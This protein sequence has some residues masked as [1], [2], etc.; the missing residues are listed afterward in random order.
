MK[1]VFRVDASIEMGIG[2]VM[3]CLTL[4]DVLR[5][6]GAQCHF[7][8]RE[9][10]GNMIAQIADRGYQIWPLPSCQV[11][12]QPESAQV[13]KTQTEYAQW[14]GCDWQTDAQETV[15]C[16]GSQTIDWL[17]VD[18][19][20]LDECWERQLRHKCCKLMVIDDLANRNHDCDVLLDQ[21]YGRLE[22]V[23]QQRVSK[24]CK[25][26]T[27]AK[28]ALLRPEFAALRQYSLQ[29]R[30]NPRLEH[31]LIS[32]GGIDKDNITSEVLQALKDSFLPE[33]CHVSVVMGEDAPWLENVKS[34]AKEL[35]WPVEVSVNVTDMAQLMADCD[36][37]IGAAGST[38]W[39]RCC[40]GV[41]TLMM[42]L[43]E[44]QRDIARALSEAKAV[45][46]LENVEQL[47]QLPQMSADVLK[48]LSFAASHI[49]GGSG[50]RLVTRYLK[51]M[52]K[53]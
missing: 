20:V 13:K 53:T 1:I 45:W 38:T 43:A 30:K 4:A 52:E 10:P 2:H 28:Y 51:E 9:L 49:T 35:L 26:L 11:G 36:L 40:L 24:H 22:S 44:N 23:Y 8:C 21:T 15:D 29:R 32:M 37:A 33:G 12:Q 3:R 25:I 41:P 47:K 7:V 18:H 17:V 16:I 50:T 31:L 39:E 34:L 6:E 19:Y 46:L 27:G 5:D 42:V 14:L 48:D